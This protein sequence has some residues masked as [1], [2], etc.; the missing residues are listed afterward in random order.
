MFDEE[1]LND[2]VCSLDDSELVALWNAVCDDMDTVYP[3]CELEV[4]VKF[5]TDFDELRETIDNF[6]GFDFDV[7][8]FYYNRNGNIQSGLDIIDTDEIVGT[9]MED[10]EIPMDVSG[11]VSCALEDAYIGEE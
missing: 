1:K 6:D 8:Y 7:D 3:M 2:A 10:G 5:P 11:S 4:F 9:L